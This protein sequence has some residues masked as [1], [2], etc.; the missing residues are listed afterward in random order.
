MKRIIAAIAVLLSVMCFAYAYRLQVLGMIQTDVV[1]VSDRNLAKTLQKGADGDKEPDPVTLEKFR[2]GDTVYRRGNNLYLGPKKE[3]IQGE[4]PFYTGDGT[5]IWY[6]QA[7]GSLMTDDFMEYEP[8][9]GLFVSDG[10]AFDDEGVGQDEDTYIFAKLNNGLYMNTVPITI[11]SNGLD[12]A[13]RLGSLICFREDDLSAY[14]YAG[15]RLVYSD[16]KNLGSA[17]VV[18]RDNTYDYHSFVRLIGAVHDPSEPAAR[19]EKP[20]ETMAAEEG[21]HSE[22][23]RHTGSGQSEGDG[24]EE[25]ETEDGDDSSKDGS[26]TDG[27]RKKKMTAIPFSPVKNWMQKVPISLTKEIPSREMVS[28][29]AFL[30]PE[31]AAETVLVLLVPVIHREAVP[32]MEA[33]SQIPV[34]IPAVKTA[35]APILIT[36]VP[37]GEPV[38]EAEAVLEAETITVPPEAAEPVMIW[39]PEAVITAIRKAAEAPTVVT[40]AAVIPQKAAVPATATAPAMEMSENQWFLSQM[41]KQMY[42]MYTATWRSRIRI[43][44]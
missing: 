20:E 22:A 31:E 41:P 18:I 9:A 12:H 37:R 2:A 28:Q 29:S 39:E 26:G 34:I 40:E 44:V 7:T 42:I 15:E 33:V 8:Y 5:G 43:C 16:L 14:G 4:Y 10:T 30:M 32:A 36:V 21:I 35:A 23:D 3:R 27:S 13:L 6:F 1:A 17:K 38:P 24:A 19:D 11:R 25:M